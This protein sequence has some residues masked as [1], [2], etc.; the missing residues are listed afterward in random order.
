MGSSNE[1]RKIYLA[2]WRERFAAWL[3]DLSIVVIIVIVMQTL[4]FV[5]FGPPVYADYPFRREFFFPHLFSPLFTIFRPWFVGPILGFTQFIYWSFTE[6]LWNQSV[7]KK[8]LGL[9]VA[10]LEGNVAK[11]A[12]VILES[13]GKSFLLWLD[14]I[15]GIL[16]PE[17]RDRRQRLTSYLSGTLVVRI[18]PPKER[19]KVEYVR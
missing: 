16:I 5:T 17:G 2:D 13:V 18:R 9:K 7:G 6:S 10:D 8:I 1:T 14:L 11:P 4:L 12:N 15:I 3:I 19:T